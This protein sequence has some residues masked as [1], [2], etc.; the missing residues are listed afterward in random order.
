LQSLK[1]YD[2]CIPKKKQGTRKE[3]GWHLLKRLRVFFGGVCLQLVFFA[4]VVLEGPIEY[5]HDTVRVC[6]EVLLIAFAVYPLPRAEFVP[7][8][9]KPVL[10]PFEGYDRF[11]PRYFGD[12]VYPVND[13]IDITHR[14]SA[15]FLFRNITN[16]ANLLQVGRLC[17]KDL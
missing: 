13:L 3:V 11:V 9:N 10:L 8:F 4:Y 17:A 7:V 1:P 15:G 14:D 16:R 6:P 12:V 2:S 5:R